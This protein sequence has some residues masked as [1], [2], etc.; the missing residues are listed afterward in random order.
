M[1]EL[2]EVDG[3]AVSAYTLLQCVGILFLLL[4]LLLF[5]THLQVNLLLLLRLPHLTELPIRKRDELLALLLITLY[6]LDLLLD[7]LLLL[8]CDLLLHLLQLDL[9]LR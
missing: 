6:L 8:R 1:V 3:V 9:Y 5:A 2:L 7:D 4:L